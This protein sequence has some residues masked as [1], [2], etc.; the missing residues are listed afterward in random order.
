MRSE[1]LELAAIGGGA[2]EKQL[3]QR[4]LVA[5]LRGRF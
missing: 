2:A 1:P 4:E 3:L 5:V